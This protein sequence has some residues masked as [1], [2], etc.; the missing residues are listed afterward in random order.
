MK[1]PLVSGTGRP[2]VGEQIGICFF[3]QVSVNA[4]FKKVIL[5]TVM[6]STISGVEISDEDYGINLL[7]REIKDTL[8]AKTP[9]LFI[10][11]P[12]PVKDQFMIKGILKEN[13]RVSIALMNA[14]GQLITGIDESEF[15][16]TYQRLVDLGNLSSGVYLMNILVN[17]E[18]QV[19]KIIKE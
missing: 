1:D 5:R 2:A 18:L 13:S 14:A 11:Y 17:N 8:V 9:G 10:V 3:G 7:K 4:S 6:L 16:G 12:N 19:I 15:S